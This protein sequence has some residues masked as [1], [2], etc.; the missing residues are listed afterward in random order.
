MVIWL[1]PRNSWF[2]QLIWSVIFKNVQVTYWVKNLHCE[3]CWQSL[4]SQLNSCSGSLQTPCVRTPLHHVIRYLCMR[5][6]KQESDFDLFS[7]TSWK[8]NYTIA[9]QWFLSWTDESSK[10]T[11]TPILSQSIL[12]LSPTHQHLNSTCEGLQIMF[13]KMY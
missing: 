13:H 2:L 12:I 5:R 10:H 8:N 4:V 3:A 11:P 1:Q 7:D 9:R 6:W